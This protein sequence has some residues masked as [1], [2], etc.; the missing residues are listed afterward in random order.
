MWGCSVAA[1]LLDTNTVSHIIKGDIPAVRQRLA[2]V[3]MHDVAVSAI[4]Q[5]E[6]LYGV[7]KRGHPSGLSTRVR[8]FLIRV[9]IL[10]WSSKVAQVYGDLRAACEVAGVTL[11]AMDMMIA[12]HAKAVGAILVTRDRA[13]SRVHGGLVLEDWTTVAASSATSSAPSK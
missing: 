12:A 11:A 6:L 9:E 8:E 4:T 2:Q 3:P 5:A 7:A 1:Y 13:F 10:S